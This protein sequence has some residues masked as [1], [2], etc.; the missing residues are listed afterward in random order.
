MGMALALL[1]AASLGSGLGDVSTTSSAKA[2]LALLALAG[3]LLTSPWV[4]GTVGGI[5]G[6]RSPSTAPDTPER[7]PPSPATTLFALFCLAWITAGVLNAAVALVQVFAPSWPDG[8]WIAHS[9][10]PGRAVGNLRQ[11]NHLSSLLLWSLIAVAGALE[12]RLLG[13]RALVVAAALGALLTF[14]VVLTASR[15]GLVGIALIALWGLVD[16]RLSGRTRLLLLATPLLYGLGWLAM[17]AWADLAAQTFGGQQRLAE[18]DLSASRFG[19]WANTLALIRMHP[20]T[21]VGWGEFNFAWTLTPFPDRPTAF[22]DHTH[23]LPL[24]L[25]VELGLPLA[26]LVMG[27]LLWGLVQVWRRARAATGDASTAGRCALMMLL[28]IG[29]HSLL[30]YPLWYA[31]FLLPTAWVWGLALGLPVGSAG[32]LDGA[33]SPGS[34]LVTAGPDAPR[35][36]RPWPARVLAVGALLAVAGS[37]FAVY[38][39]LRVAAIFASDARTPLAERIADGQHSVFSAHHAHY[40]AATV[41]ERPSEVMESF[42]VAAHALLDTRLMMAWARAYA[43]QG[44]LDRARYLAERL[45]EFRNPASKDFFAECEAAAKAVPPQPAPFQCS[46]PSRALT[47]RDFLPGRDGWRPQDRK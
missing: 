43:E 21:G 41:A 22:F 44:D 46:P 36:P 26:A 25:A 30:E 39:Y 18:G 15:T 12:L 37:V 11:P 2:S 34:V 31:Y 42:H 29:L 33:A 40:A 32:R 24:Q 20:W 6:P 13:R 10:L 27:L 14:A 19:I 7:D 3:L 23:N 38:D 28:L 5:E 1:A 17:A 9:S 16:R 47:W 4:A 8:S 45:R 35:A